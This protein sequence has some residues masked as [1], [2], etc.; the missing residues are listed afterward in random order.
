MIWFAQ[1]WVGHA[2]YLPAAAAGALL[3]W[4]GI[5]AAAEAAEPAR[6]GDYVA[7]QVLGCGLTSR[8]VPGGLPRRGARMHVVHACMHANVW[9]MS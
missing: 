3:P 5:K 6:P 8:W 2:M 4:L 7:A 9:A 1:H